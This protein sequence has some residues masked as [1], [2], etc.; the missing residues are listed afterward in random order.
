MTERWPLHTLP[1]IS[2]SDTFDATWTSGD[3]QVLKVHCREFRQ[4]VNDYLDASAF[5]S[6]Y[7]RK[8]MS[9]LSAQ[10]PTA[11]SV[12]CMRRL[13]TLGTQQIFELSTDLYDELL[14]RSEETVSSLPP[15]DDMPYRRNQARHRL[16][17]LSTS[18]FQDLANDIYCELLRR[19]PECKQEMLFWRPIPNSVPREATQDE[20]DF[21]LAL[22]PDFG[23]SVP[24]PLSTGEGSS[25]DLINEMRQYYEVRIAKMQAQITDLRRNVRDFARQKDESEER[26]QQLEQEL[27]SRSI[28][29]SLLS[30]F[31]QLPKSEG[32][33]KFEAREKS[34]KV[35]DTRLSQAVD[36]YVRE[37]TFKPAGGDFRAAPTSDSEQARSVAP[38]PTPPLSSVQ[39]SNSEAEEGN[40]FPVS[41]HGVLRDV[42]ATAFLHSMRDL[43][44]AGM[45][46]TRFQVLEAL[47]MV[48]LVV[49]TIK[50]DLNVYHE[51][52]EG[53]DGWEVLIFEKRA[54]DAI[55]ALASVCTTQES[56]ERLYSGS[57]E[58]AAGCVSAVVTEIKQKFGIRVATKAE[59]EALAKRLN[60]PSWLQIEDAEDISSHRSSEY[61]LA[62]SR[63]QTTDY[64]HFARRM[65][66][67]QETTWSLTFDD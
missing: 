5:F 47:Q 7:L 18:W 13:A 20:E 32:S 55:N 48:I 11:Q 3:L 49:T 10:G 46:G 40:P 37:D 29:S 57:L 60:F 41:P 27:A 58:I 35:N 36:A 38:L 23:Q 43:L 16:A 9:Y 4:Y 62:S 64:G 2:E 8:T 39:E 52:L 67:S 61:S 44:T 34:L 22:Y 66:I 53:P 28:I 54:E 24:G 30:D 17:S 65:A 59:Q 25:L 12:S 42:K 45:L 56:T 14:R 51:Q 1:T 21:M 15:R 26:V 33:W 50:E 19:F 6:T 31:N 63:T